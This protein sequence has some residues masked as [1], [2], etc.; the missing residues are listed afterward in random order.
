MDYIFPI[1]VMLWV[2]VV[3]VL[4]RRWSANWEKFVKEMESSAARR[5][6]AA[7]KRGEESR[8]GWNGSPQA[9]RRP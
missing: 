8:Q 2:S 9:R 3:A 7:R 6:P 4:I 1:L 5:L